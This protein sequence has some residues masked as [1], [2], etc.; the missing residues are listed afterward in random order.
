VV[1]LAVVLSVAFAVTNGFLSSANAIATLVATGGARPAPALVLGAVATFVGAVFGGAAVASTIIGIVNVEGQQ[2]VAVFGAGLSGALLWN[3][4]AWRRGLPASAGHALIGGL[5][6]AALADSGLS[7]VNWGGLDGWKPVGFFG[8]VLA[9]AVAPLLGAGAAL[10]LVR[11]GRWL[12]RRATRA[13][14]EPIRVGQRVSAVALALGQGSNDAQKATGV[15]TAVLVAGG[16]ID[17]LS[18]PRW[19]TIVAGA[20]L[21]IGTFAGGSSVVRTVGRRI[22]RLRPLDALGTGVSSAGVVLASTAAGAPISVSQV[23]TSSVVG[24]GAGRRRRRHIRWEV[25]REIVLAWLTTI[26]AA[27]ALAAVFL[28]LWRWLA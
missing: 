26:P 8:T 28:P 27:A 22:V 19:L 3:V 9:L 12:L 21:A 24:A 20:A 6:G 13:F 16:R 7:A 11:A 18:V 15:A 10:V 17:S 5:T 2:A 4:A 1:A 23:T 25:V 14:D